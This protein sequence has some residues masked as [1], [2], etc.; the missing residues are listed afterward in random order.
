[1]VGTYFPVD[2]AFFLFWLKFPC[3]LSTDFGNYVRTSLEFNPSHNWDKLLPMV[4]IYVD[5]TVMN[6]AACRYCISSDIYDVWYALLLCSFHGGVGDA[7]G[8]A[9]NSILHHTF[10]CILVLGWLLFCCMFL[11]LAVLWTQLWFHHP[12]YFQFRQVNRVWVLVICI[13]HMLR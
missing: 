12:I 3:A 9:A 4:Y 11:W 1:M 8:C 13:P 5:V 10:F 2:I 6:S 7:L